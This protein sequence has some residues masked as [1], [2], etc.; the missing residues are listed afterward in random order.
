MTSHTPKI[1][2]I[3]GVGGAGKSRLV[4][5]LMHRIRCEALIHDAPFSPPLASS[6]KRPNDARWAIFNHLSPSREQ[7]D[8]LMDYDALATLEAAT[9]YQRL[10]WM[11]LDRHWLSGVV[12]QSPSPDHAT[13]HGRLITKAARIGEPDMWILLTANPD[14]IAAALRS[15]EPDAERAHIDSA[16]SVAQALE[17]QK[18]MIN[19]SPH[20]KSPL[21]HIH[22][23]GDDGNSYGVGMTCRA[24]GLSDVCDLII[25]TMREKLTP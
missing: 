11:I 17:R 14:N 18:Q 1:L 10:P 2:A 6:L 5:Q 4:A 13:L 3:E 25:Q 12:Y 23:S 20:L 22:R 9:H 7:L 24:F 16:F 15:R 19:L 8:A 21:L